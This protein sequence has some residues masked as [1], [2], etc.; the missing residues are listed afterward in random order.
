MKPE[1]KQAETYLRG[2]A[3]GNVVWLSKAITLVESSREEHRELSAAI[4]S[5]LPPASKTSFR[6]GITGVPGVGKSSFI[7][8]FGKLLLEKGHRVAVLAVDPSS[9]K[10]KG[11]ILGDKT[12]MAELST[13]PDVYIRP[14]PSSGHLGGLTRSTYESMLLCEAAGYDVVMIETVGVGQSETEVAGI[15]DFFLLLMLAGAGDELQG[16]KRGIMEMADALLVT[17][18]D[19]DNLPKAKAAR[20]EYAQAMHLLG[21]DQ[22]DW[23]PRSLICSSLSGEGLPEVLA[24]LEQFK[25]QRM[26]SGQ[27]LKKRQEQQYQL[28]CKALEEE[29]L[30]QF[31][32]QEEVQAEMQRL[33]ELSRQSQILPFAQAR[34]LVKR[35]LSRHLGS[36]PEQS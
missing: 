9:A 12:R 18:A 29:L 6:I 22:N 34:E 21:R 5:K 3:E 24:M 1:Q 11:S 19:G 15:C 27:F 31:M 28:Y 2:V 36:R 30:R 17:K 8:R 33:R 23:V 35:V 10:S 26:L 7:E 4:L 13:H 16:I 14:S 20:S 25:Q 32:K